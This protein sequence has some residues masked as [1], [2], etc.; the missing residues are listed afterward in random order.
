MS[1]AYPS[2]PPSPIPPSRP[3]SLARR[4]PTPV[5]PD[6][7]PKPLPLFPQ[8]S[9]VVTDVLFLDFAAPSASLTSSWNTDDVAVLCQQ[10]LAGVALRLLSEKRI[11]IPAAAETALRAAS[12]A[13]TAFSLQ[14][15][16]KSIPALEA[17]EHHGIPFA[18]APASPATPT[19]RSNVLS[20]TSTSS[21]HPSTSGA[22]DR[23]YQTWDTAR[24]RPPG[25]PGGGSTATAGRP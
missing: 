3:T 21:S 4:V 14:V 11:K 10:R 17:L 18:K 2:A 22:A 16:S 25:P 5:P 24:T 9:P 20:Q 23:S 1:S 6:R 19:V 7:R 12:F 8:L 13:A 15:I